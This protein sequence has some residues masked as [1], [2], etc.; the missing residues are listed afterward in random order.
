MLHPSTQKLIDRL[1]E[2]TSTKKIE[3]AEHKDE[4]VSYSTEGYS[5]VLTGA[6]V[7]LIIFSSSEKELERATVDQLLAT[8]AEEGGT[9]SDIVAAM[10]SEAIRYARGTETAISTLLDQLSPSPEADAPDPEIEAYDEPV[11]TEDSQ[12]LEDEVDPTGLL[13][14]EPLSEFEA[15]V[16]IEDI[17][18]Q[19]AEVAADTDTMTAAV[20]RLADEVNERAESSVDET[21]LETDEPASAEESEP[22]AEVEPPLIE[23][24]DDD[25]NLSAQEPSTHDDVETAPVPPFSYIP[26]GLTSESELPDAPDASLPEEDLTAETVS[27]DS[28]TEDEAPAEP[29]GFQPTVISPIANDDEPQEQ[30]TEAIDLAGLTAS[31]MEQS[32]AESSDDTNVTTA[33]RPTEFAGIGAGTGLLRTVISDFE[34]EETDAQLEAVETTPVVE[35]SKLVIDATDDVVDFDPSELSEDTAELKTVEQSAVAEDV[36]EGASEAGSDADAEEDAEPER[37]RFNPWS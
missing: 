8:P 28:P 2:M 7:E 20:A 24:S 17:D 26:F 36:D 6:P 31:A 13:Q 25:T 10:Q 3:W 11:E 23:V 5:V 18:G 19:S 21:A 27:D 37:P 4:G 9:Y 16:E 30:P 29:K 1:A 15:E 14:T 32:S 12:L 33:E 35:D 34:P 22:V